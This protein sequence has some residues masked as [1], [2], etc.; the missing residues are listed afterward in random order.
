MVEV[1]IEGGGRI[2]QFIGDAIVA[3]FPGTEAADRMR[4]LVAA[5]AMMRRN[6]DRNSSK[7]AQELRFE[8]GIGI[9]SGQIMSGVLR[10]RDRSEFTI[11]G[12]ARTNA[13]RFE[14]LSKKAC[15]TRIVFS[16]SLAQ[17]CA[18]AG[19]ETAA[20]ECSGMVEAVYELKSL[21]LQSH[22]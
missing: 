12:M 7:N 13:E 3:F 1:I 2:E 20:V 18:E 6:Q 9:D 5:A 19:V 11:L 15:F 10:T 4:T 14:A 8:I 16:A 22:V 17:L 21:G